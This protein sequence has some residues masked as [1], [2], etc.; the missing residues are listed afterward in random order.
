MK[1]WMKY[2]IGA[3]L[4]AAIAL[5]V[6]TG[7]QTL[8]GVLAFL[9][10]LSI[11]VGRY[12]LVPL[13]LFSVPVAVFELNEDKEFWKTLGRTVLVLVASVAA[14]TLIG[15]ITAAVVRP[16]R[17]PLLADAAPAASV[18]SL[19]DL[20]LDVFP[21]SLFSTLAAPGAYLLPVYFLA[22]L[23]GLA[24]SFDRGA[25]KPVLAL[26]DS[27]SRIFY[28][29]NSFFA[30]FLGVLI[31]TV[32]AYNILELRS[33]LRLDIY[34]PLLLVIGV[35]ALAMALVAIPAFLYFACGRKNPY[36]Y[37]YALLAPSLGALFSG[38]VYFALGSLTKHAKESLGIRRR[39]NGLVLPLAFILGRAGTALVTATAFIVVLSSYSNLGIS[40]GSLAWILAAAPLLTFMLSAAPG[41]GAIVALTALCTLYGKGFENGY[42]IV[43]PI[44]LPLAAVGAFLDTLWAGAAALFIAKRGGQ[45][46]DKEARFFI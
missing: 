13:I 10:E 30:E 39:S 24:F 5:V 37:L 11:R 12:A 22:T 33:S 41:G 20:L 19:K 9:F 43:A 6:P 18:L 42:L 32:A 44:A 29:I 28:Q 27:F 46:Q 4:G 38:D 31:I 36:R 15:V 23:L 14:F 21:P 40:V 7:D 8:R 17:I 26:F 35:E 3:L 1:I 34:R 25:T 45:A 16:A 2:L